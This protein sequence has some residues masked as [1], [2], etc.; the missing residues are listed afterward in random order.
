MNDKPPHPHR[1]CPKI[2]RWLAIPFGL[3]FALI[4]LSGAL[5]LYGPALDLWL[6]PRL[7]IDR[8]KDP[9]LPLGHILA[10]VRAAH[11]RRPGSWT[12]ELPRTPDGLL[13]AWYENPE[14]TQG[15]LYAPL[16]VSVNP[17]TAEI[18]ASRFW[19]GTAATRLSDWHTQLGLG[20]TGW[21]WVGGL[22]V[23]LV[24]TVISGLWLGLAGL[25]GTKPGGGLRLGRLAL[26]GHRLFGLAIALP[27]LAQACTGFGL[28][29][30]RVPESLLGTSGMG[31]D[32]DGP[33][34]RSTAMPNDR[35][36][37]L[38]EAVL[39]ARGPFPHAEVRRVATPEGETGTYR[40]SLRQPWEV[41]RRH[42]LTTVWVD[43]YSGQI[44]EVRN[45][46]RF[47][48]GETTMTWLWP[49]HTGEIWGT[50]G[51]LLWFL[52][53]L[54]PAL[55]FASG[56]LGWLVRRGRV[57]DMP[58][59]FGPLWA[60]IRR[61]AARARPLASWLVRHGRQG[62]AWALSAIK[63]LLRKYA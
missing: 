23:A 42:P 40:V 4:G 22:G 46:A 35:P 51:R 6:D 3:F 55:L 53:G 33:T 25:G 48:A 58:V 52:A 13:T 28:A 8:P 11:P 21:N 61:L 30:P 56:V 37:G 36:V 32:D 9:P 39:L 24:L 15:R 16:M 5:A 47:G 57:R 34:V 19:G 60:D 7:S 31:H 50:G 1:P 54:A 14:E 44:R 43:Q 49:L 12:L 20:R 62:A 38:D 45:P 17:Y 59:E 18:V 29:F 10:A 63:A 27:L 2:H 41:N 26:D